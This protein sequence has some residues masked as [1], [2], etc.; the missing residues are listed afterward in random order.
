MPVGRVTEGSIAEYDP[1]LTA[2]RFGAVMATTCYGGYRLSESE[3][4]YGRRFVMS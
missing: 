1:S 3:A 4:G 2:P